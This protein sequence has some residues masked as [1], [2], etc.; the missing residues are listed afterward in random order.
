MGSFLPSLNRKNLKLPPC[1]I[2][3]ITLFEKKSLGPEEG[4]GKGR[5]GN[6]AEGE[7]NERRDLTASD[8]NEFAN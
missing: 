4:R 5:G 1:L 6:D 3:I 2:A 7:L 8:V